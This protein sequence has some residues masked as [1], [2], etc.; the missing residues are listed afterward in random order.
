[1]RREDKRKKLPII[2][3]VIVAIIIVCVGTVLFKTVLHHDDGQ[4]YKFI[5]YFEGTTKEY[6]YYID[7]ENHAYYRNG[8]EKIDILLPEYVLEKNKAGEL[9]VDHRDRVS[10]EPSSVAY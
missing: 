1:M 9:I 6:N 7:D 10:T 8:S 2:L 5:N 4:M 3:A